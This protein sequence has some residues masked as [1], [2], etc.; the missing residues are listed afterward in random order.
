MTISACQPPPP[1]C[2][3]ESITYLNKS[4]YPAN[5]VLPE[6]NSPAPKPEQVQINGKTR[7]VDKVVRGALCDDSWRGTI[8]VPCQIQIYEWEEEADF[9]QHCNLNIDPGTVVYVAAHN[10]EPYYQ[11]CSCHSGQEDQ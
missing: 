8:Y 9:L 11:G 3:T 5:A 10:D 2:P 6:E 7:L 1:A 4:D